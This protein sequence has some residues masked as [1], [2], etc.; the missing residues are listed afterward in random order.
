MGMGELTLSP[1]WL[2]SSFVK[3]L[4]LEDGYMLG[5]VCRGCFNKKGSFSERRYLL[6]QKLTRR[7]LCLPW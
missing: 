3:N 7:F 6:S 5:T 1:K 4:D 2:F